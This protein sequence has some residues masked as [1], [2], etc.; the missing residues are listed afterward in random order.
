MDFRPFIWEMSGEGSGVRALAALIAVL[1][2][3][4]LASAHCPTG[5]ATAA[6]LEPGRY[7]VGVRTLPLVDTSRPTPAHGTIAALPSRT[8]TTEIWYPTAPHTSAPLRDG[9][10]ARGRFPLVLS[11]HGYSDTRTGEAY[12]AEARASRGYKVRRRPC[13]QWPHTRPVV[14]QLHR[15]SSL[16]LAPHGAARCVL[17]NVRALL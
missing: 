5:S 17:P 4:S 14:R 6:F 2:V 1:L 9:A 13:E 8:L 15:H 16:I 7:G 3:P 12:V 10:A 11:S